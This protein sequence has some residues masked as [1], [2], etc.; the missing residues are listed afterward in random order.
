MQ[1]QINTYLSTLA[2]SP[3]TIRMYDFALK[4]FQ[5]I[6]GKD[7][8][9]SIETYRIFLQGIRHL[10]PATVRVYLS[11]VK[12]LFDYFDVSTEREIDKATKHY[13]QRRGKRIINF[14]FYAIQKL[15]EFADKN[16]TH[17]LLELRDRAFIITQVETGLRVGEAV[18]RVRSDIEGAGGRKVIIGKGDKQAEIRFTKRSLDAL[19]LYLRSRSQ[20]DG[21]SNRPIGQLP[22]FAQHGING[23]KKII[24]V[25]ERGISKSIKMRMDQAGID[26][27]TIRIHDLRHFFTT[28]YYIRTG[29]IK[30]TK[31]ASR[32]S[33]I[34]MTDRYTHLVEEL[35]NQETDQ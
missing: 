9:L 17:G 14:D 25:S 5:L 20:L 24:P 21:A 3:L 33:S 1:T 35:S 19:N 32:H 26:P 4:K 6:V 28:M 31:E 7:A 23:S 27:S 30:K 16:L 12:G 34:E 22:L 18:A 8:D 13:T 2:R 11:P 15:I 29:D 10:S